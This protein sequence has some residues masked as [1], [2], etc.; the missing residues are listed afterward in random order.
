MCAQH[1]LWAGP[2]LLVAPLTFKLAGTVGAVC[3]LFVAAGMELLS[4]H[5]LLVSSHLAGRTSYRGLFSHY[6]ANSIPRVADA[7][8]VIYGMS[9]ITLHLIVVADV[10]APLLQFW[11]QNTTSWLALRCVSCLDAIF[12]WTLI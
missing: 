10:L 4:V 9:V 2:T 11:A 12:V 6:I 5:F 1:K 3:V 7:L 8:L